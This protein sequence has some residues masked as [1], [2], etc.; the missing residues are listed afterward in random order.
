MPFC[1]ACLDMYV[2]QAIE[3]RV[4]LLLLLEE[5]GCSAV[6]VVLFVL[7]LWLPHCCRGL[8]WCR[9]A[10]GP[11][12]RGA[13]RRCSS[14]RAAGSVAGPQ[15][16]RKLPHWQNKLPRRQPEC[17]KTSIYASCL[18]H[19]RLSKHRLSC[20]LF[21]RV[22]EP[23]GKSWSFFVKFPGPGKSWKMILVLESPGICWNAD[24]KIF[25]SAHLWFSWFVLTVIKHFSSLHVSVM[26]I[27]VW[28]LL[29]H[30]YM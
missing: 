2:R 4:L 16:S 29:S 22:P 3:L 8:R 27:A 7:V 20:C 6:S 15:C 24:A 10:A 25:T 9:L 12:Q 19:N 17:L 30:S 1:N 28:M 13:D 5:A 23:T 26:N 18:V 21:N 14:S 11:F